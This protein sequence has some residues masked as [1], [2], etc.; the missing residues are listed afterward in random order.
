MRVLAIYRKNA[1]P[2][3]LA[4]VAL[5]LVG[6]AFASK[7][8]SQP[9]EMVIV[10]APAMQSSALVILAKENQ[11]FREQGLE[12]QLELRDTGRECLDQLLAGKVN[13]AVSFETPVVHATLAGHRLGILTELHRSEENTAII[14]RKDKSI[15]VA[16]DL[17]GKSIGVVP[18]TTGEFLVDLFLRSHML[19]KGR[20][21]VRNLSL[22]QLVAALKKG[23]VSAAGLWEPVIGQLQR[24]QPEIFGKFSFSFYTEF[25][26]LV[27]MRKQIEARPDLASALIRA[28]SQAH[29]YFQTEEAVAREKVDS[30]L[31]ESGYLAFPENWPRIHIHLGLSATLLTMLN[32]E[33]NWYQ[34]RNR[35]ERL[36]M[37]VLLMPQFLNAQT[38][39]LVTFQ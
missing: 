16:R 2:A 38:P 33:A 3:S 17:A 9:L 10:C 37:G 30:Y 25:S 13:F 14:F 35:G 29:W 23:T 34:S 1:V 27:G 8:P 21:K 19:P 11:F 18:K 12:I 31:R 15:K 28:L 39:M 4:V 6:F 26:S 36:D 5:L 22:D 32:E 7:R 20:V 24:E